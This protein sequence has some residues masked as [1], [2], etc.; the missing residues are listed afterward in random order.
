M[1]E[2]YSIA[3]HSISYIENRLLGTSE[4][5]ESKKGTI[6]VRDCEGQIIM[7][8]ISYKDVSYNSDPQPF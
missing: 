8:K 4:E 6:R 7:Y 1:V 3:T 2:L 5:R